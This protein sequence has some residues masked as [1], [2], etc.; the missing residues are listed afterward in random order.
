MNPSFKIHTQITAWRLFLAHGPRPVTPSDR[1][2]LPNI[3]GEVYVTEAPDGI[4]LAL[5]VEHHQTTLWLLD[6]NDDTSQ[7]WEARLG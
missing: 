4:V 5:G 6:L 7:H 2:G 1:E 3:A